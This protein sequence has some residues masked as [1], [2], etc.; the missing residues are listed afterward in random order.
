[1]FQE[2]YSQAS[3]D[4]FVIHALHNKKNGY[5]LEIGSNDPIHINNTYIL[6]KKYG[7]KGIM[8]EFEKCYEESYKT[9]RPNSIHIIDDATKIDYYSVLQTNQFPNKMDYLQ[10][11]LEAWN[12]STLNTLQLLDNTVFDEYTFA[13]VTFEHDIYRGV[14]PDPYKD[15]YHI[16]RKTSREIFEKRGYILVFPD[17]IYN[18]CTFEDWY[19]HPDLV[20]INF[21][22]TLKTNESLRHEE[23]IKAISTLR[24]NN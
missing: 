19:M 18:D 24:S 9:E 10:I 3:Q 7:W 8:V 23:C 12:L 1:M 22:N 20:D 16:T 11:D 2:T 15:N 13:T 5:F 17:V 4:L 14:D 6:E 21:I